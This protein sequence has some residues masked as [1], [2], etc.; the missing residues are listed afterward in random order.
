VSFSSRPFLSRPGRVSESEKIPKNWA[1][2][3]YG[4]LDISPQQN[5]EALDQKDPLKKIR[6]KGFIEYV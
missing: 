1:Q 3:L 2:I 6:R 4:F 5:S